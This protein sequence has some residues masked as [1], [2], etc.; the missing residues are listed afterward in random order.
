MKRAFIVIF[1]VLLLQ[2]CMGM[3]HKDFYAQVAPMKYPPPEK[4]LVFEYA[5]VDL[6]EIYDLLFSDFLIIGRSEFSGPYED[7][8]WSTAFANSIG[9]HVFL[10]SSQFKETRTSF[11]TQ[12]IPTST[13]TTISGYSGKGSFYGTATTFGAQTTTIPIRIDRY[14]QEGLYLRNI[15]HVIALW[16]RTDV[17][18]TKTGPNDLEGVWFNEQ[19]RLKLYRSGDQLVA[20]IAEEPKDRTTWSKGQLKFIYGVDTGVGVY[21]MGNKTPMP[22]KFKLNKFGHLEVMLIASKVSFSFAR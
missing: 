6:R 18:Y 20:F 2:G 22:A 17:Q 9:A 5:N 3:G 11:V 12:S 1:A 19:L 14:D 4:T 10:S 15:N 16:E 8:T 7:P 13:T 21:L